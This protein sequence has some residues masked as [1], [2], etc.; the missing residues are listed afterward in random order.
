MLIVV[1]S[2][3]IAHA[4]SIRQAILHLSLALNCRLSFHEIAFFAT[5]GIEDLRGLETRLLKVFNLWTL[6]LLGS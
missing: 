5:T 6:I 2:V 3:E 1:A 4:C